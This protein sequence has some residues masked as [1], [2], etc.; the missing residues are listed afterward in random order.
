MKLQKD[1]IGFRA[2]TRRNTNRSSCCYGIDEHYFDF[3]VVK[4]SEYSGKQYSH[5]SRLFTVKFLSSVS[6]ITNTRRTYG[7][8]IEDMDLDG[9]ESDFIFKLL[10]KFKQARNLKGLYSA[11]REIKAVRIEYADEYNTFFP[12]SYRN[13]KDMFFNALAD[14]IVLKRA[15]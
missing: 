1:Y 10:P 8:S 14:G 3:H 9:Y 6:D 2:Y 15:A 4:H 7:F 5:N 11:I 12:A 13:H